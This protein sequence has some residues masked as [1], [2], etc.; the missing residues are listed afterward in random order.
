M[1]TDIET[2]ARSLQEA[3]GKLNKALEGITEAE[4]RKPPAEGEWSVAQIVGHVTEVQPFL[5]EK[6]YL[7]TTQD[8]PSVSRT[9][10]ERERRLRVVTEAEKAIWPELQRHLNEAS[11]QALEMLKR[12]RHQ[13]LACRGYWQ[14]DQTTV[15][16][17]VEHNTRHILDH[18]QQVEE[19]RKAALNR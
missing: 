2:L 9:P 4:L 3:Q 5:M 10:R 17:I 15:Q 19:A 7:M 12:L 11:V 18:T 14:S 1:T 6:A 13:D 8:D 16:R